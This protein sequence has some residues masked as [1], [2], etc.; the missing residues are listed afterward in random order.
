VIEP[1]GNADAGLT[2]GDWKREGVVVDEGFVVSLLTSLVSS[3]LTRNGERHLRHFGARL[4]YRRH[5]ATVLRRPIFP[6]F[7]R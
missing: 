5:T 3:R 4:R 2:S 6:F 1:T 7:L